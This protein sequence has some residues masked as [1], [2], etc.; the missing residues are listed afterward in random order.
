[1]IGVYL[2]HY[3]PYVISFIKKHKIIEAT[4][5]NILFK[6]VVWVISV[7]ILSVGIEYIRRMLCCLLSKNV[8]IY[9]ILCQIQLST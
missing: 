8:E 3:H 6:M 9:K 2:I 1:M 4:D 5:K 7:F